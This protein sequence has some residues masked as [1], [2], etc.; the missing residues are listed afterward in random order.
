MARVWRFL[1]GYG[2]GTKRFLR[3]VRASGLRP[4]RLHDLRHARASLVLASGLDL[5]MV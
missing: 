2:L 1:T 4:T 5:S 3:L